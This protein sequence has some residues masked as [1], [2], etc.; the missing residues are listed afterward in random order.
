MNRSLFLGGLLSGIMLLLAIA[1]FVWTPFDHAVM[2]IPDKLQTPNATHWLGTDHFG[3]DILSMV[4]VGARTSLAVALLAVGIG[5]GLG[6]PLQ[7]AR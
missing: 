7:D 2:N 4:M 1:S 3:R 5:V 6:V